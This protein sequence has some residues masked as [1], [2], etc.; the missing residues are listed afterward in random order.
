MNVSGGLS[1]AQSAA[2]I[3]A[4]QANLRKARIPAAKLGSLAGK[5]LEARETNALKNLAS[6]NG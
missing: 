4:I 5:A 1:S 3:S 2:A 6:P